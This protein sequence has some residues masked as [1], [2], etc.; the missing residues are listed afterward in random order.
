MDLAAQAHPDV[1]RNELHVHRI[2]VIDGDG[3]KHWF[4]CRDRDRSPHRRVDV[5]VVTERTCGAERWLE[6]AAERDGSAVECGHTTGSSHEMQEERNMQHVV[7]PW[8]RVD[9]GE[10]QVLLEVDLQVLKL[11]GSHR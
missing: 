9:V 11:Q 3:G 6:R 5:A 8:D 1:G 10:V 7:R 4:T 2:A